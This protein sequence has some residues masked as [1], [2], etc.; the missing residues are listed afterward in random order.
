MK[1]VE[2][3]DILLIIYTYKYRLHRVKNPDVNGKIQ[4]SNANQEGGGE[5]FMP[6]RVF[7]NLGNIDFRQAIE[8]NQKILNVDRKIKRTFDKIYRYITQYKI[9]V[10]IVKK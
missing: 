10:K 6:D 2:K 8:E 7:R 4:V 1:T 3:A 9:Q 5:F